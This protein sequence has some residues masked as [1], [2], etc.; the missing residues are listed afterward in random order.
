MTDDDPTPPPPADV[1]AAAPADPSADDLHGV[2]ARWVTLK[3]EYV[4]EGQAKRA[5]TLIDE[6]VALGAPFAGFGLQVGLGVALRDPD[7]AGQPSAA[8]RPALRAFEQALVQELGAAG[9]IVASM[10]V[11]GL[12]EYVAYVRGTEVLLTWRDAVPAGMRSHDFE[13]QVLEDPSWLG[14]RELAGLL[15][16]GEEHLGPLV[17]LGPLGSDDAIPL[18]PHEQP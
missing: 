8:E 16:P 3:G 1:P 9:R 15:Q 7:D 17:E 18:P 5:V 12:R 11:D 10:T 13:V 2:L 14:L 4:E 6:A